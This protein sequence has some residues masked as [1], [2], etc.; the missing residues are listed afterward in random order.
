MRIRDYGNWVT[1]S[2]ILDSSSSIREHG[3]V[4]LSNMLKEG[5]GVLMNPQL[6]YAVIQYRK[7]GRLEGVV[8]ISP[9][10]TKHTIYVERYTVNPDIPL[11]KP[12]II[13][14]KNC[15]KDQLIEKLIRL[16]DDFKEATNDLMTIKKK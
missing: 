5:R 3:G 15:I 7:H 2:A 9:A 13:E 8:K 1:L 14:T 16:D 10:I 12:T 4:D 6:Y 11:D